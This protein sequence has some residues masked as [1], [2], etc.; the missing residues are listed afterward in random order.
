MVETA[1]ELHEEEIIELK[2]VAFLKDCKKN[3]KTITPVKKHILSHQVIFA[4][5]IHLETDSNCN[6]NNKFIKIEKNA[7]TSFAVPRLVEKLMEE[8][9]SL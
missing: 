4:R 3:L 9:G 8:N 7:I 2:N 5:L 1:E 6:L